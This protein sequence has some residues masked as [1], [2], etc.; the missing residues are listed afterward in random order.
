[1]QYRARSVPFRIFVRGGRRRHGTS[2]TVVSLEEVVDVYKFSP[3]VPPKKDGAEH[4]SSVR[5]EVDWEC[6]GMSFFCCGMFAPKR[7][8]GM[9]DC[10][11]R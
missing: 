9:I 10:A 1:M 11:G 4:C 2:P 3:W 8:G 5:D 7:S 6:G